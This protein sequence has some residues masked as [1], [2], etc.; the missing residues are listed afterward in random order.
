MA[1]VGRKTTSAVNRSFVPLLLSPRMQGLARLAAEGLPSKYRLNRVQLLLIGDRR[2]THHLPRLL[3]QHMA[4]EV[5]LRV[6]PGPLVQ[7]V[8]DQ[9]D[10][11]GQLV[12]EATVERVVVPFVGRLALGLR[13]RLLG[14]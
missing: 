12:V 6:T 14:L 9:R 11:T 4:G 13:Q 5:I 10:R 2:K 3:R 7:P 8:H 1:A